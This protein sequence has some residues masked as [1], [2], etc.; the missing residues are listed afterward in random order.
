[1]ECS[2]GVEEFLQRGG[3]VEVAGSTTIPSQVRRAFPQLKGESSL[4]GVILQRLQAARGLQFQKGT[5]ARVDDVKLQGRRAEEVAAFAQDRVMN[6]I[7]RACGGRRL[8]GIDAVK[9]FVRRGNAPRETLSVQFVANPFVFGGR[10]S[11]PHSNTAD[12]AE[13]FLDRGFQQ[14]EGFFDGGPM[15]DFDPIGDVV[16]VAVTHAAYQRDFPVRMMRT[17]MEPI[18]GFHVFDADDLREIPEGEDV[19]KEGQMIGPNHP[20]QA[21]IN[22][23]FASKST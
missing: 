14:G 4:P 22:T 9:V 10:N 16:V 15:F 2:K 23:I 1:V 3:E 6:R 17:D 20:V 19:P 11:D 8:E 5:P 21:D 12:P 13:I 18:V 7:V